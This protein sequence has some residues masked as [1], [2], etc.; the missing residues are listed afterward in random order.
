MSDLTVANT[1]AQQLPRGMVAMIGMYALVGGPN[2]L[3]F[4]FK[5]KASNGANKCKIILDNDDLYNV[6]F[7]KVRGVKCELLSNYSDIYAESLGEVFVCATGLAVS[8]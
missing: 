8:L 4:S 1:I 6:E 7:Y 3:Q 5:A 2:F